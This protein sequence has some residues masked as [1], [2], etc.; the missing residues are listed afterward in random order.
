MSL[1]LTPGLPP[2]Q[3]LQDPT[4]RPAAVGSRASGV[5]W[6]LSAAGAMTL[7][8]VLSRL[9]RAFPEGGGPYAY[10]HEAFGPL[11]AQVIPDNDYSLVQ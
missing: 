1:A 10:T 7:A 8:V 3:H 9:S 4:G 5:A 6:L 2:H 11:A